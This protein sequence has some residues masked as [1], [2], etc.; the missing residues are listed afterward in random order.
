MDDSKIL[1]QN[2]ID[3]QSA[4]LFLYSGEIS[5]SN[6]I[7]F[8]EK[9]HEQR[10]FSDKENF[11]LFLCTGGGDPDAGYKMAK[12]I[13]N[14]YKKFILYICGYCKSAGTL[15]ALSADEIVMSFQGELGP[16][17]TQTSKRDELVFQSSSLDL[18]TAYEYLAGNSQEIFENHFINLI[19]KSK[20]AITIKTAADI[21]GK[22]ANGVLSPILEQIDPLRLGEIQREIRIAYDYGMRLCDNKRVV[23]SLIYDYPSHSFVIDLQEA[24]AIFEDEKIV[25]ELNETETELKCILSN[26]LEKH[27]GN[28]HLRIPASDLFI[29]N[30]GNL[31]VQKEDENKEDG[32]T[33]EKENESSNGVEPVAKS[34]NG[35]GSKSTAKETASAQDATSQ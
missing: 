1:I 24:K 2:I 10:E 29:L 34:R 3:A 33:N 20:G 8:I 17:D 16:L 5:R 31:L 11:C 15:I 26:V 23:K 32:Q 22:M 14:H 27:S 25:R 19:I 30:L 12:Y 9:V 4:D 28:N 13:K 7:E 18:L 21:A 6:T 35:S